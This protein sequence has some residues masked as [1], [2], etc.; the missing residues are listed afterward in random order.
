MAKE[1]QATTTEKAYQKF[2]DM[3]KLA[4]KSPSFINWEGLE[5]YLLNTNFYDMDEINYPAHIADGIPKSFS[6]WKGHDLMKLWQDFFKK[7]NSELYW[8]SEVFGIIF[9][10]N[11]P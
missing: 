9:E 8:R 6:E 11:E 1:T 5:N 3:H 2:R 7:F 4:L 10:S